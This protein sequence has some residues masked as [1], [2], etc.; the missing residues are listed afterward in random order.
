MEQ[1]IINGTVITPFKKLPGKSVFVREGKIEKIIGSGEL[2]A[3][4]SDYLEKYK[5]IDA[6]NYFIGPGFID[7][8]THGANDADAVK[9]PLGPMSELKIKHGTTSF[10]PTL[11]TAEFDRMIEAC[12]RIQS[13]IK[14]QKNGSRVLGINSEGPYLNP[15]LGAQKRELVKNPVPSDYNRLIEAAGGWLKIMT[16]A[17]ELP[18]AFE[19]IRDLRKEN[20]IVS[21]GH[22]NISVTD[23]DKA[24]GLGITLV[25]HLFDAMGDS[26]QYDRGTKPVGIQEELLVRKG[27]MYELLSDKY[28]IHVKPALLKIAFKCLG[29]ENIV[30][31]TD[32]MNMT[33]FPPG[34]YALQDSREVTIGKGE[35]TVRLDNGDLAGSVMTMDVAVRNFIN[36]TGC[37]IEEAVRA[38][39][40]N[41]AKVTELTFRKGEVKPGMDAD[42]IIFDSD[43]NIKMAMA[44]GVLEYNDL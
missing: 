42:L 5:K 36:H 3:Y 14:D 12:S 10:F 11:W 22:T 31:I 28:G 44:E 38:A 9:D 19:L 18:G 27:L 13:F 35:D 33:G 25:T 4:P 30:L 40:F 16:V 24:L 41:P 15:D 23:M 2:D 32:S 1:Y 37:A 20:I 26:I 8:H 21:I 7:I 29:I 6:G 34:K 39:S 43:I 17:P